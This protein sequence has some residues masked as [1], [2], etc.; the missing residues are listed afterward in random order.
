M[1]GVFKLFSLW[2]MAVYDPLSFQ[3][4]QCINPKY[5]TGVWRRLCSVRDDGSEI[6]VSLADWGAAVVADRQES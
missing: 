4:T 1:K 6:G 2:R 5:A 3:K